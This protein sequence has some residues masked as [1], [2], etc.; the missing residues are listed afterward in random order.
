V[1][2]HLNPLQHMHQVCGRDVRPGQPEARMRNQ[3]TRQAASRSIPQLPSFECV[4]EVSAPIGE[5]NFWR[6]RAAAISA[7]VAKAGR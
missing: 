3:A 7:A 2:G 6:Q 1:E 5:S 4:W